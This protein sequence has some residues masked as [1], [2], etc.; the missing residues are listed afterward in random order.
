MTTTRPT[1]QRPALAGP[2]IKPRRS[3]L[4]RISLPWLR[5]F[6]GLCLVHFWLVALLCVVE[7]FNGLQFLAV[8]I[9]PRGVNGGAVALGGIVVAVLVAF[10]I[11]WLASI[12]GAYKV[13]DAVVALAEDARASRP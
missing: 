10:H 3:T 9:A 6:R 12:F 5:F 13:A 1:I 4:S 2:R 7:A 11:L 8:V